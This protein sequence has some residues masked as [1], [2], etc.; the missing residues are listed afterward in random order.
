MTSSFVSILIL[1]SIWADGERE[2]LNKTTD[3]LFIDWT[4]SAR[5]LEL[6]STKRGIHDGGMENLGSLS[7]MGIGGRLEATSGQWLLSSFAFRFKF[8]F[9]WFLEFEEP[10]I[11]YTP[12]IWTPKRQEPREWP[13]ETTPRSILRVLLPELLTEKSSASAS[14]CDL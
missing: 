7:K 2:Y 11:V 1:S 5:Q 4:H 10:S 8:K 12:P 6:A 13:A 3:L 14:A 9:S